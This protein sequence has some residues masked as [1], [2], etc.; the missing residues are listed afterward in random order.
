MY[1]SE[2]EK[3]M[4]EKIVDPNRKNVEDWM[5]EVED[6]MKRSVRKAL[7]EGIEAYPNT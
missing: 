2:K 6:M 1:S 5:Q 4:F 3:V 7:F